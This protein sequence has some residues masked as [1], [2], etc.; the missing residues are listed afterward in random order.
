MIK[1]VRSDNSLFK[2]VRFDKGFNVVLA[3]R[4]KEATS[5]DS[6][7]GLGKTTLIEIIHF[8][9]GARTKPNE[10][11]RVKELED[12]TFM[13]DLTLRGKD[14][15][16]YRNTKDFT[17]VKIE[18]DISNW[19]VKPDYDKNE[20][21]YSMKTAEWS[22]LL[23]YL[24]FDLPVDTTGE[25][26]KPTFRSLISYFARRGVGAFHDPFSHTRKQLEFDIQINNAYLLGLN[27][28]YASEFQLLKDKEHTLQE[29]KKAA[30]QGLLAGVIGTLGDMEAERV[31]LEDEVIASED[32]LKT[33]KVHP[34]YYSVYDEANA[35]HKSIQ[36]L[37]NK[38]AINTHIL[39]K[40]EESI[41]EEKDVSVDNVK[42]IYKEAGLIFPEGV[43]K[44]IHD[45]LEFHKTIVLNR[46]DYLKSEI[47]RIKREIEQQK[48]QI[49]NISNKRAELLGILKTHGALEE[50]SML[51]NRVV[52]LRQQLEEVKSRIKNLEAFEEGK[53]VLKI[54]KEGLLQKTH[55][56]YQERKIQLDNARKYFNKNSESLYSEPGTLSIDI[57]DTGYKYKVDIKRARSQGIGY[58]KVFCYDLTLIQLR[59]NYSDMP[60]FLIHDSTIFDGVDERQI[61][62]ALE[63]AA[64]EAQLKGFQYICT[65]NSDIV[66][67]ADFSEKFRNEFDRFVCIKFTDATDDGGLL[68]FR[69]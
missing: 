67:S 14:Y 64:A 25:K 8:C 59:A 54:E 23:G 28:E 10:G 68:G 1:A 63:L 56:D 49:E 20:K 16:I 9:F 11:L 55:R 33:F 69:F 43:V 3:E 34:Q 32:Q 30:D 50:Y 65:L 51:Q 26:Y 37:K 57:K 35:L 61:A 45:T 4:K 29:L 47:A 2:E 17:K 21:I 22:S 31:R 40:Y 5:K 15:T 42:Q 39:N 66:P 62:K 44:K 46:K 60:G 41:T 53:S 18:G 48:Y 19:P 24:M 36:E 12:W 38:Y 52:T 6:R 13:L 27:W 7:N 58:M